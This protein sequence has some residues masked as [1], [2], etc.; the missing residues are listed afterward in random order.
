MQQQQPSTH[1]QSEKGSNEII[2]GR[3]SRRNP[4]TRLLLMVNSAHI[5]RPASARSWNVCALVATAISR[6]TCE[7][8][9]GAIV[10]TAAHWCLADRLWRVVLGHSRLFL[11][12][13][14]SV[15]CV[16]LLLDRVA[17]CLVGIVSVLDYCVLAIHGLLCTGCQ[18]GQKSSCWAIWGTRSSICGCKIKPALHLTPVAELDGKWSRTGFRSA[19]D[20]SGRARREMERD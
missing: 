16:V 20:T 18:S 17:Y 6:S 19:P 2:S 11:H 8:Q 10:L 3:N 1:K 4:Y 9:D 14:A 5:V 13:W 7:R 12:W 15:F